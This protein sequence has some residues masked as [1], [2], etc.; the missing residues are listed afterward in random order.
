Q[1]FLENVFGISGPL[2]VQGVAFRNSAGIAFLVAALYYYLWDGAI[3]RAI[4]ITLMVIAALLF[5]RSVWL[6]QLL[7]F[8]L[9]ILRSNIVNRLFWLFLITCVAIAMTFFP[10]LFE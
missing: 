10:G 4:A 3:N 1:I 9:V 5:S 8:A 6:I 7:F 2:E